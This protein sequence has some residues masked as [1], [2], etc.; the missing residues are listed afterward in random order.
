V[1]IQYEPFGGESWRDPFTFYRRLRDED[2]VHFEERRNLWVLSRFADVYSAALDSLRFSSA[3]GL[4]LTNEVEALSL[5]PTMVMMD[6]PEHTRIRRMV[7]RSFAP[8][9]VAQI[10]QSLRQ[11]VSE[12][13]NRMVESGSTDLVEDLARPVPC[14]V[15][16]TYLGVP[17]EDRDLFTKWTQALVQANAG[18]NA[19][20]AGDALGEL[21]NYFIELVASRR[22]SPNG[23]M[24]SALLQPGPDG[25]GM[26][27][28]EAL[29]Y[30]FVM[31]AGGNDTT[32]GLIAGSAELLTANLDERRVL[33]NDPS[34]IPGAVN[35]LLRLTSPVQGL[36]R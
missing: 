27:T 29:G 17:E 35:E 13:V 11:Y 6:P 12:C 31:I 2:P 28:E 7:N 1:P 24:M 34:S 3:Q 30:A 36:C 23:D 18:G 26:T 16:A 14:F 25:D 5:L 4:S 19:Y 32:T 8:R 21:Y 22:K 10:E 9:S 33:L 15:V 20:G